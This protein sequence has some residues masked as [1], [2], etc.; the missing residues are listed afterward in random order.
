M[1]AHKRIGHSN[2]SKIAQL[3]DRC[4][5]CPHIG[6]FTK[7]CAA[8]PVERHRMFLIVE[9]QGLMSGEIDHSNK[10]H[11]TDRI[12]RLSANCR[13][14]KQPP[15]NLKG[16]YR[17]SWCLGNCWV[18]EEL[19]ACGKLLLNHTLNRRKSK[20]RVLFVEGLEGIEKGPDA[21]TSDPVAALI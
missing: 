4:K 10:M 14:C 19:N 11:I 20:G 8:C 6:E 15:R 5:T 18:A 12:D 1:Q 7:F 16:S 13:Q 2:L 17:T 21:G 9:E 3:D